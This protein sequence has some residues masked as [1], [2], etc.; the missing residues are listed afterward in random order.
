M[1]IFPYKKI[2]CILP[3]LASEGQKSVL[4]FAP[5]KILFILVFI[6][7]ELAKAIDLQKFSIRQLS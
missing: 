7:V 1:K 3:V 6:D 5:T 4:L 2:K